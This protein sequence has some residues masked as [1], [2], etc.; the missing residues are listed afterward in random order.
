VTRPVPSDAGGR[1]TV[2]C[3][4]PRRVRTSTDFL[5]HLEDERGLS[6][7]HHRS[8]RSRSRA[9]RGVPRRTTWVGRSGA[10]TT[11]RST[12]WPSGASWAGAS[13]GGSPAAAPR[14]SSRRPGRS[15]AS[16]TSRTAFRRIPHGRPHPEDGEAPSGPPRRGG[17]PRRDR[18]GEL[19]AAENTLK[20]TRDLVVLELLYGSGLRLSELHGST[21]RVPSSAGGGRSASWGRG[22]RSGSCPSPS[23]PCAPSIGTCP[24]RR[25]GRGR[26]RCAVG[27]PGGRAGSPAGP[28]SSTVHDALRGRGRPPRTASPPTRS[29]TPSRPT[30]SRPA[31]TCSP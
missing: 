17:R 2:R 10:G 12:V 3:L 24:R 16:C 14:E 1:V 11:P 8:V 4:P 21:S 26:L 30:C 6:P 18:G 20:G 7:T 27:E 13:A 9:A 29:G 15:S 28:S 23:R 25:G 19:R 22:G 31:R 5:S